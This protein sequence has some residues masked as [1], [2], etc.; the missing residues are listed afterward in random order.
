MLDKKCQHRDVSYHT[1]DDFSTPELV[2]ETHQH[3]QATL[4]NLV[5]G[6]PDCGLLLDETRLLIANIL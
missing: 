5:S 2:K 3:W 6:L 1:V 4:G